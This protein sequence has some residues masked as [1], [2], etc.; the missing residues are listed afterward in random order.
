[1]KNFI[2]RI[3]KS[4]KPENKIKDKII[5]SFASYD[6]R[7]MWKSP[8]EIFNSTEIDVDIITEIIESYNDFLENSEGLYTTKKNYIKK[9]N[10]I[11]QF[12]DFLNGRIK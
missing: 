2:K 5:E 11:K 1:M 3:F 9:E 10:F 7:N 4:Y 6:R 8:E 12:N